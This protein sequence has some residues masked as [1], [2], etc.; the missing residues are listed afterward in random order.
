MKELQDFIATEL[1]VGRSDVV[2]G[3]LEYLFTEARDLPIRKSLVRQIVASQPWLD[4]VAT[5]RR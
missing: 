5:L 3:F 4:F 1:K 2:Q